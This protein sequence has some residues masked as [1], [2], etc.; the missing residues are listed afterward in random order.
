[1]T[2]SPAEHSAARD[3]VDQALAEGREIVVITNDDLTSLT[4]R[5]DLVLLLKLKLT[6]LAGGTSF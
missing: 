3:V 5:A 4:S 6:R 1:V 2:G